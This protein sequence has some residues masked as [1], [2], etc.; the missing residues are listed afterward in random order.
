MTRYVELARPPRS[1]VAED[2]WYEP[3]SRSVDVFVPS[4]APV[5]TG[6]LSA[7]GTRIY[8]V[9]ERGPFGFCREE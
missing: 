4:D 2:D 1:V 5:D 7:N 8:R 3:S 9:S 6:L